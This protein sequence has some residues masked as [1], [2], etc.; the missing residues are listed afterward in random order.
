MGESCWSIPYS[1]GEREYA[2]FGLKGLQETL[3][4]VA[5]ELKTFPET[6]FKPI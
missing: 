5:V 1:L 4:E 3:G 2:F 6:A